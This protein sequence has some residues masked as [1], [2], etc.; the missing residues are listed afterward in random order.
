MNHAPEIK[1]EPVIARRQRG[2][3]LDQRNVHPVC[4]N[5][6]S[7]FYRK[8]QPRARRGPALRWAMAGF[9]LWARRSYCRSMS[10]ARFLTGACL[11][12]CLAGLRAADAQPVPDW[13]AVHVLNRLAY[14]PTLEDFQR[15]KAIGVDRYVAEQLA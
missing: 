15:V 1:D 9:K 11:L 10:Y 12:I 14:G 5:I 2:D 7:R 4:P 8:E 3:A 6:T 13:Q